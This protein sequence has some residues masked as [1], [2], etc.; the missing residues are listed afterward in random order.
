MRNYLIYQGLHRDKI[1]QFGLNIEDI[2]TVINTAFA[3]KSAGLV[4][5]GEK[6]F[7][8]VVRVE[9]DKRQSIDDIK[10]VYVT[11]PN[12]NQIPLEQLANIEYKL[13]PNQIQRDDA[14]RRIIVGF[15]VRGKDVKTIVE[16]VQNK[17]DAEI[18]FAPGYYPSYGGTF[19]NL[20]AANARLSI[21][22]PAALLLI[23]F[24]LYLT[25]SSFKHAL[26]T[27]VFHYYD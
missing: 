23:L 15:N 12:G 5:E 4:F 3:G 22:V 10:N 19:E 27:F 7:D 11:A 14:K 24:L 17:L 1:A 9:K 18:D 21:A 25:F 13:G 20:E 16:E 6:R 8:L 2:N 26:L